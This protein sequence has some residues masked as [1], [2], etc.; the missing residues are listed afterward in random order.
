MP[1]CWQNNY[2]RNYQLP[3]L[4]HL[5]SLPMIG[6]CVFMTCFSHFLAHLL[7]WNSV[8]CAMSFQCVPC[9]SPAWPTL[10][11]TDRLPCC[12]SALRTA[13]VYSFSEGCT[14]E[15]VPDRNGHSTQLFW[16]V[17]LIWPPMQTKQPVSTNICYLSDWTQD[18]NIKEG[19]DVSARL[20]SRTTDDDNNSALCG[21]RWKREYCMRI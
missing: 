19:S 4:F 15:Q 11:D 6:V 17:P 10:C 3:L 7:C 16:L 2:L 13:C 8:A 12:L 14:H 21:S 18:E 9:V 1:Q 20:L 5:I